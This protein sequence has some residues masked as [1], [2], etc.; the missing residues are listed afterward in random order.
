M[1]P[2]IGCFHR[3]S[4]ASGIQRHVRRHHFD[5]L[6]GD[7]GQYGRN[8]Q[9]WLKNVLAQCTTH[10][11]TYVGCDCEFRTKPELAAHF[12]AEHAVVED[13]NHRCTLCGR[14]FKKHHKLK[15]HMN[16]CQTVQQAFACDIC[17]ASYATV[18]STPTQLT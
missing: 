1:C 5:F 4:F 10:K 18:G 6:F 13:T 11:C 9:L 3:D 14:V 17:G 12:S 16:N 8:V 15:K 2:V 7:L